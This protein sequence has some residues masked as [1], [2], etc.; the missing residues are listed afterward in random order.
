M[1]AVEESFQIF[2]SLRYDPALLEIPGSALKHAGWNYEN[3]SPLYM[4]SYHRDRLLR[5]ANHWGWDAAVKVL[6][7]EAGLRTL[8]ESILKALGQGQE[9]PLK[10]R[11][12]VSREGELGVQA[13]L[14]AERAL[15][16]LFP[17]RLPTP[18]I[19]ENGD[20]L[21]RKDLVYEVISD[22]QRIRRSEYTHFKTTRRVMYD[23]ARQRAGIAVSDAKE[24]LIINGDD[25]SIM[26]GS[27][28]TP[29]FRRNGRWVTP[30]VSS[31]FTLQDGSGGNDGTSRRWALERYV[32]STPPTGLRRLVHGK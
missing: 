19:D 27:T 2:T 8:S 6:S 14:A 1:A 32:L 7:G 3:A 13:S 15:A 31:S 22:K 26:E 5:A 4:L 29:Y 9:G 20:T 24:V 18:G 17:E 25:D 21:P 23:G 11:V 10:V 16:N 28:T 30:P 12:T